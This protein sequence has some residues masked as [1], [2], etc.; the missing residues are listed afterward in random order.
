[1]ACVACTQDVSAEPMGSIVN[2]W[3]VLPPP[4]DQKLP[5]LDEVA[6]FER[7]S[8]RIEERFALPRQLRVVHLAC[9]VENAFYD[10]APKRIRM[11][12]ELLDKVIAITRSGAEKS[13]EEVLARV[14]SAWVL[15]FLHEVGHAFIDI[16]ELPVL[17]NEEDAVDD[18]AALL[19][20]NAG[21]ASMAQLAFGYYAALD[22][23]AHNATDF[24]DEHGLDLQR[25]YS[26]LCVV[27][28]SDPVLH[29][30]IVEQGY[31]SPER[32][33]RCPSEYRELLSDWKAVLGSRLIDPPR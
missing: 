5:G 20:I 27:Y 25:Y 8:G 17:G 12:D 15:M 23:A 30:D 4:S 6:L 28:G 29:A 26:G 16:F 19:L 14:H 11:C 9:G 24:A 2:V 21:E 3:T 13:A 31:L 7:V 1:M 33:E 22:S 18:F 10:P 32:A